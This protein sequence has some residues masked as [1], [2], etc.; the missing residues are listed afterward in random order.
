[1]AVVRF[2]YRIVVGESILKPICEI[3]L[4]GPKG[5]APLLVMID[6]GATHPIFPQSAADELGINLA[7]GHDFPIQYGG[8]RTPGRL[9]EAVIEIGGSRFR[10]DAAFVEKLDFPY[11]LLGRR[12]VF[13]RFTE[14]AFLE[15]LKTPRV[16]F[17]S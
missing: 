4:I 8:S 17:R 16:E 10:V 1:M 13:A 6:S 11:G 7:G 9:V 14:V 15:K 3:K 5:S 12:S 2:D